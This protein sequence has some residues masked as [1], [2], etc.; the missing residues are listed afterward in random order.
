MDHRF[1]PADQCFR[2]RLHAAPDPFQHQPHQHIF[3]DIGNKALVL[4]RH[5]EPLRL[6]LHHP[7]QQLMGELI[8]VVFHQLP[9]QGVV[10]IQKKGLIFPHCL[11]DPEIALLPC[12]IALPALQQPVGI[13]ITGPFDEVIDILEVIVKGHAADAAVL[14][15]VVDGDL[16][17]G[18]F[19]Q[20]IFQ[21]RLQGTLG[22]VGHDSGL[23]S[24]P[25]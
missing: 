14:G 21:R 4:L 19:P 1:Q 24:P 6:L 8:E 15:N 13:L 22:N 2:L 9:A 16:L 25:L 5:M 18:L 11:K 17:Q 20:E 10:D 23:P 12:V 3:V 7:H